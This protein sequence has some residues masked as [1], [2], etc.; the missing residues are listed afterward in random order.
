MV[1]TRCQSGGLPEIAPQ[2]YYHYPA[3][4][5]SDLLQEEKCMVYAA[6]VDKHQLKRLLGCFHHRLEPVVQL[7]YVLFLV[8]ERDSNRILKHDLAIIPFGR[9]GFGVCGQGFLA[10]DPLGRR[11]V[12]PAA[13]IL[14]RAGKASSKSAHTS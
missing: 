6:I 1:E 10:G 13:A 3:V 5:G 14:S 8:V 11:Y 4:Y 12:T 7:G 2:L 9:A